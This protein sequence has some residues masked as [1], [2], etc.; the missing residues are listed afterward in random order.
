MLAA[1]RT[2]AVPNA[3]LTLCTAK[4]RAALASNTVPRQSHIALQRCKGSH[5]AVLQYC[6][7]AVHLLLACNMLTVD[8]HAG[9]PGLGQQLPTQVVGPCGVDS[10]HGLLYSPP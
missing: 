6:M 9:W 10:M 3:L 2:A 5:A 7:L 1:S 4:E 8:S